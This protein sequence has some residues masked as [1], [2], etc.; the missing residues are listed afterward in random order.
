MVDNPLKRLLVQ[1]SHCSAASL[2]TMVSGA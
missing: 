2:L 1:K